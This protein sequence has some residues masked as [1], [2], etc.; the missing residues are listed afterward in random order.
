VTKFIWTNPEKAYSVLVDLNRPAYVLYYELAPTG[1]VHS[2]ILRTLIRLNTL[3]NLLIER[4][5]NV[6]SVL[7]LND[8]YVL[9]SSRHLLNPSPHINSQLINVPSPEPSFSSYFDWSKADIQKAIKMFGITIDKFLLVSGMYQSN[10]FKGLIKEVLL[11]KTEV[12]RI[13]SDSQ[14]APTSIFHPLCT[15]CQKMYYD[16][17]SDISLNGKGEYV[18]KNCGHKSQFSVY[19]NQGLLAF[20]IEIAL[21]WKFLGVSMDFHGLNHVGA[22]ECA[23]K[24]YTL[25]FRMSPPLSYVVN[26][27][28]GADHKVVRKSLG[29][30]I[31]VTGLSIAQ[32]EKLKKILSNI[33]DRR[34]LVLPD[35]LTR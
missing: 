4:G 33:S 19:E 29:N 28:I 10:E 12:L 32:K 23:E 22:T 16:E 26:L 13:I 14:K 17:V 18:C 3:R 24:I 20:K 8:R 1:L 21:T 35:T 34:L 7:R 5:L 31:P 9:K 15:N 27:T 2:G 6:V 25:L 11:K 30:F